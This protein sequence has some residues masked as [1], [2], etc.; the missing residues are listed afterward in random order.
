MAYPQPDY[1]FQTQKP[2]VLVII[3]MTEVFFGHYR[4]KKIHWRKKIKL[5]GQNGLTTAIRFAS[6]YISFTLLL[7]ADAGGMCPGPHRGDRHRRR[8]TSVRHR[9]PEGPRTWP[10][11]GGGGKTWTKRDKHGY[12]KHSES[13]K[14]SFAAFLQL[15]WFFFGTFSKHI[16][17]TIGHYPWELSLK[18]RGK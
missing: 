2:I 11:C 18:L 10:L 8:R 14:A 12:T 9:R 3:I 7:F 1:S 4:I 16:F 17:L 6:I 5:Q 15:C 13:I